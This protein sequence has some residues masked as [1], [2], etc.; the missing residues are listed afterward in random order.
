MSWQLANR[1]PAHT[2]S[3]RVYDVDSDIYLDKRFCGSRL[4]SVAVSTTDFDY[5]IPNASAFCSPRFEPGYDLLTLLA[6]S[7]L[8]LFFILFHCRYL[9]PGTLKLPIYFAFSIWRLASFTS[10]AWSPLISVQRS[11]VSGVA[12]FST[13]P[14]VCAFDILVELPYHSSRMALFCSLSFI[15]ARSAYSTTVLHHAFRCH[16]SLAPFTYRSCQKW[17]R[18]FLYA[19]PSSS[20][21][22]CHSVSVFSFVC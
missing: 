15:N 2:S 19:F 8:T 21:D 14:T 9:P 11:M 17:L 20:F 5:K 4:Y 3:A 6:T 22:H 12:N 16:S 13:F 10:D 1:R 18:R 7:F